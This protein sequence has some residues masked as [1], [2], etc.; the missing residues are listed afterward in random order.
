MGNFIP[1]SGQCWAI[2][3]GSGRLGNWSFADKNKP[4]SSVECQTQMTRI[5]FSDKGNGRK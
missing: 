2:S 1:P 5:P 4:G 3:D